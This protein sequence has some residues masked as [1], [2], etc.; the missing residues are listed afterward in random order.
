T[1]TNSNAPGTR[2]IWLLKDGQPVAQTVQTGISDGRNTEVS[3]EGLSEGLAV[4]TDQR[5]GTAP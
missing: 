4:I 3:G 1:E 2:Q 5:T